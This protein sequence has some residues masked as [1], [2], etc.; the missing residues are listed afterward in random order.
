[1]TDLFNEADQSQNDDRDPLEVLTGPGGKYD[2]SKYESE[3]DMWKAIA[4][5]KVEAD[6]Y[7]NFK[8]KEFDTL[9]QDYLG[10]RDQVSTGRKLEE[11]IDQLS[12]TKQLEDD[13]NNP[14]GDVK[15]KPQFDPSQL[16]SIVAAKLEEAQ[17]RKRQAEN[18]RTVETKL[19][20]QYGNN[21]SAVLKQKSDELGLS[22]EWVNDTARK[23]PE[24]LFRALSLDRQPAESFQAPVSSTRVSGFTPA[25]TKRNNAY[26]EKMRRENPTEYWS[27]KMQL[28][29]LE[30][31]K[32]NP[33]FKDA[34][35]DKEVSFRR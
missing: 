10:L 12:R 28:Q 20:E 34:S 7:I 11:V 21:Y 29:I 32:N 2:K 35:W 5:G 19:K 18:F 17:E 6:T 26:Y 30:D 33:E 22:Q 4:K 27:G 31:M 24:V 16:D 1:M 25:V 13:G 3:A 8:N 9:R 23:Y 14:A 15:E